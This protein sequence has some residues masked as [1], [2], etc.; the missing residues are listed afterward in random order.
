MTSQPNVTS[1]SAAIYPADDANFGLQ[2]NQK[3]T[4]DQTTFW[5]DLTNRFENDIKKCL[6]AQANY[7]AT[8]VMLTYIDILG[9]F[10]GGLTKYEKSKSEYYVRGGGAG[11]SKKSKKT[12]TINN[13][14]Y[15]E[16]GTKEQ[17]KNFIKNHID[18]IYSYRSSKNISGTDLIYEH[19]RCGMIHE[20]NPR[21]GMGIFRNSSSNLFIE[22]HYTE[23]QNKYD[24]VL[25]IIKLFE[26]IKCAR[27]KFDQS[28]RQK[29]RIVRWNERYNFLVNRHII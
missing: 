16:S 19:F 5:K 27:T 24:I 22:N 2:N 23:N 17:F 15:E 28:L 21:F 12:K 13:I 7:S 18:E 9:S 25:N 10:Y 3:L 6:D 4:D 8:I 26:L 11:R 29:N 14:I 20:G 1:V